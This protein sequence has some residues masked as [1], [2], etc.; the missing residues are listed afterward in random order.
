MPGS[1]TAPACDRPVIAGS[2]CQAHYA[3]RRRGRP[4]EPPIQAPVDA[5]QIVVRCRRGLVD[6]L[7]GRA[8]AEG[9]TLSEAA[10]RAILEW[11]GGD[12]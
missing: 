4:L 2:L 11:V 6:R 10:R 12:A 5:A 8:A 3:R 7:R 1:C 9:L